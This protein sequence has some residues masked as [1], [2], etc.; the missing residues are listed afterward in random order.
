M[1]SRVDGWT[2]RI[3]GYGEAD[4]AGLLEHP[5]NWRL[6]DQGQQ[7]VM[8]ELLD[9]VGWVR[10]VIVNRTT[11]HLVDGHLRVALAVARGEAAVPVVFVELSEAEERVVLENLDPIGALAA[12]D[13]AALMALAS[14]VQVEHPEQKSVLE[15][16]RGLT[17]MGKQS[18][19]GGTPTQEQIDRRQGEL[20][21]QFAGR[22]IVSHPATC[23]ECGSEF[24]FAK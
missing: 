15:L 8:A 20:D 16:L 2:N 13:S 1:S 22:G 5:D 19:A 21:S 7:R 9:R 4:P 12:T 23:P 24:E 14:T 18:S 6:H 11:G 3:A 10:S 17:G